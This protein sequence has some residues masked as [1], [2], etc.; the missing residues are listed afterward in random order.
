MP[1]GTLDIM[2]LNGSSPSYQIMFEE[3]AGGTFVARVEGDELV[4]FMH[5]D[6]RIDLPLAVEAARQVEKAGR[7]RMQDIFLEENN[8]HAAMDYEEE[9]DLGEE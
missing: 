8:L 7:T 2:K 4:K 9:E 5:E 3:N 1:V 6:M